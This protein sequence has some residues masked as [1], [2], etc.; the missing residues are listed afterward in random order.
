MAGPALSSFSAP[1]V[2]S[3]AIPLSMASTFL[4]AS[5]SSTPYL[6]RTNPI[7]EV[8][9]SSIIDQASLSII[10]LL[11]FMSD[12]SVFEHASDSLNKSKPPKDARADDRWLTGV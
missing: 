7:A 3:A 9:Q 1:V 11:Q 8:P 4:C 2:A 12:F 10:Q 6:P 5:S